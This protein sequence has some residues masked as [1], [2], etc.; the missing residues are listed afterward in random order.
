M[1]WQPLKGFTIMTFPGVPE[2]LKDMWKE[3]G[4][5]YIINNFS[6]GTTF[7]SNTLKFAGI[8]ESSI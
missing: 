4:R 5:N 8:G 7:F 2:E 1:I 6:E 3:S